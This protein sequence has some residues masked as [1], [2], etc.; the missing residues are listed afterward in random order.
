MII[1]LNE[2]DQAHL[3]RAAQT[4]LFLLV[5]PLE[6]HLLIDFLGLTAMSVRIEELLNLVHFHLALVNIAQILRNIGDHKK[7]REL[8][9]LKFLT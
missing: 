2:Y 6:L 8:F 9:N 3:T 7:S 1:L 4:L 5:E